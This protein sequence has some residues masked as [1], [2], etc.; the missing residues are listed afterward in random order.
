MM[1]FMRAR[2]AV[3][4]PLFVYSQVFGT[5]YLV[6]DTASPAAGGSATGGGLI[7]SGS[8]ATNAAASFRGYTFASWTVSNVVVSTSPTFIFTVTS[9]TSLVANF[10]ADFTYFTNNGAIDIIKY[11]GSGGAVT[12]PAAINGLPVANIGTG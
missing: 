7:N 6:T 10:V 1:K 9:N 11:T 8:L 3:L 4:I 12:V 2:M 5:Q